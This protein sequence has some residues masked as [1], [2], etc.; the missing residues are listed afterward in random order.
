LRN[1]AAGNTQIQIAGQGQTAGTS[2]FDIINDG[3]FAV[4]LWNRSSL[5]L[6]FGMAGAERMRL[7]SSGNLGLGV[8]P[9]AW[10]STYK[11]YQAGVY[12]AFVGDNNNGRVEILNNAYA[13]A[14]NVF[15]YSDTNSAGRYS[16][17]L[18]AHAWHTAP[19]GTA[20]DAIT[21][22]QAL[23]LNTNGALVLQGGD[24]AASG[25]GITFPATQSASSD[26]NTLDDY[27][28]GT[29]TPTIVSTTGSNP[30]VTYG[31]QYGYYV[32]VGRI[33][34]IHMYLTATA[35]TGGTGWLTVAGLPF[36]T[37]N[38]TASYGA[39]AVAGIDSIP[40]AGGETQYG[41]RVS[42]SGTTMLFLL[43]KAN[44][45]ANIVDLTGVSQGSVTA[46]GTYISV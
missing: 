23:T 32:K 13:S 21:F 43:S 29:W 19:S 2:S 39:I 28:E 34:Q 18:G 37:D 24:T 26:A 44:T 46:G 5:P 22:T 31:N 1:S 10:G 33:V 40:M 12:A 20:G 11:A 14:N 42:P 30:T 35:I 16:M 38:S 27:E 15:N 6:L 4:Y 45:A 9:S 25:V 8:T 7:D 36:N 17:Q 3:T 41:L